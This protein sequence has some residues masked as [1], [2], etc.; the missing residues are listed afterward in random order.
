MSKK[1]QEIEK[2]LKSL[3]MT[4]K[5]ADSDAAILDQMLD[6][7]E[8]L[9]FSANYEGMDEKT[10][11]ETVEISQYTPADED[12]RFTV[13]FKGAENFVEEF[14]FLS[15][16]YDY[17][18]EQSILF[19]YS[20]TRGVPDRETLIEDGK[21]KAEQLE[22]AANRLSAFYYQKPKT[23]L[24]EKATNAAL[25]DLESIQEIFDKIVERNDSYGLN[26]KDSE[27]IFEKIKKN[28]G[29]MITNYYQT[30]KPHD[31]AASR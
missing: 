21:W 13:N 5:D 12:W 7:L 23:F 26:K 15:N 31:L 19:E 22:I 27:R 16:S 4:K 28:L 30:E 25:K 9:G 11:E 29:K 20:G 17:M 10:G 3:E 14:L 8:E 24:A 1:M 2:D 18:E 6:L